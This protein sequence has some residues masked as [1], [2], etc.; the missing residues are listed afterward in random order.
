MRCPACQ[1]LA[2]Y[3]MHEVEV[4]REP[5]LDNGW[6]ICEICVILACE[7]CCTELREAIFHCHINVQDWTKEHQRHIYAVARIM[8]E[9]I[10]KT[11]HVY[12]KTGKLLRGYRHVFGATGLFTVSCS[13]GDVQTL[14]WEET[15]EA[16]DMEER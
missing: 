10:E 12:S 16:K 2:T 15:R 6:L 1:R 11:E 8:L 4:H 5:S 9:G 7:D 14:C 3:T 13:C